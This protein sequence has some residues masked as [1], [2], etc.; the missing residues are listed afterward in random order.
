MQKIK[1]KD[2]K[3]ISKRKPNKRNMGLDPKQ[4]WSKAHIFL[5]AI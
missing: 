4:V 3:N 1:P 5:F 2:I